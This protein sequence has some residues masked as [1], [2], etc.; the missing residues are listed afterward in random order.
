MIDFTKATQCAIDELCRT[1]RVLVLE[2]LEKKRLGYD[3][4]TCIAVQTE[5]MDTNGLAQSI[6]F[7]LKFP[8]YFPLVMPKVVLPDYEYQKFNLLPHIEENMS[9]CTFDNELT[10][11]NPKDP[12]GIAKEC[13]KSAKSI[14]ENGLNGKNDKDYE[15]EFKSYWEKEYH[16]KDKVGFDLLSLSDAPFIST[17]LK[18]LKLN[19]KTLIFKYILHEN[20]DHSLRF[21]SY[22]ETKNISFEECSVF[23]LGEIEISFNP[24]LHISNRDVYQLVQNLGLEVQRDFKRFI[25]GPSEVKIVIASI[26]TLG[27]SRLIAWKHGKLDTSKIKGFRKISLSKYQVLSTFQSSDLVRRISPVNFSPNQKELRT[28]GIKG[29]NKSYIFLVAGI[30]SIGSNLIHFLNSINEVEFKFIDFDFLS[31]ENIGRHLLGY[32]YVH[33]NKA[34]GMR[35]FL[36][37]KNPFQKIEVKT[38]SII[39]V[40]L[41]DKDFV[42]SSDYLFLTTGNTNVEEYMAE[43]LETE[44]VNKPMFLIWV[45]PYLS[46]GHCLF[47]YPGSNS[48]KSYFTDDGLFKF[49]IID[50]NEYI[51]NNP[52]LSIKEAGCQTTFT[53]Y[54]QSSV[55]LFL[56]AIF[57]EINEIIV[58]DLKKS[59]AFSWKGNLE[60]LGQNNIAINKIYNK[61]SDNKILMHNV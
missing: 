28:A 45:E 7:H 61:V 16:V 22:L 42:S 27:K 54:S 59:Q 3:D 23:Y 1:N 19:Q 39:D 60:Y 17:N 47:L 40:F 30:G 56:A 57:P 21:L 11:T 34:I 32:S 26:V 4:V 53:P 14:I 18:L 36:V 49:N 24:P 46:G 6:T 43:L 37:D 55:T 52:I 20:E 38:T 58:S 50:N 29:Q 13:L 41:E 33:I 2:E 8:K 31:L 48:Y 12:V 44:K 10:R 5:Y 35:N 51:S 25:N 15:E 9:I